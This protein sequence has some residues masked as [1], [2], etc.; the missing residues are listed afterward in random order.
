MQI[1]LET[2]AVVSRHSSYRI[3]MAFAIVKCEKENVNKRR[4]NVKKI[5][6]INRDWETSFET[7]GAFKI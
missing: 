6:N 1:V 7:V 2:N 5:V 4:K 3:A